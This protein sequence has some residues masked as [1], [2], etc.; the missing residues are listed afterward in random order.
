MKKILLMTIVI[1]IALFCG[2]IVFSQSVKQPPKA[3]NLP[4]S[5]TAE[6]RQEREDLEQIEKEARYK[7]AIRY[8][9]VQKFTD[10]EFETNATERKIEVLMDAKQFT[11]KNLI[12]V[13]DLIKKRFPTPMILDIEV[14]TNLATIETPEEDGLQG[15]GNRLSKERFKFKMASFSRFMNGREAFT[16]TT[17]L[18]KEKLVVLVDKKS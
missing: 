18:F 9:I 11:E 6:E 10:H 4:T 1:M 14:H 17:N 5:E 7:S 16:Y 12:I 8:I 13:F 15:D 2:Y 3:E